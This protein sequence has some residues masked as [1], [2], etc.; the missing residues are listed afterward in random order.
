VSQIHM[1]MLLAR[2]FWSLPEGFSAIEMLKF[3][4][5]LRPGQRVTLELRWEAAR[6]RLHFHFLLAGA[7][8]SSGRLQL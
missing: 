3:Q 1:V 2:R 5:P 4:Q 7:P 8:A 6:R